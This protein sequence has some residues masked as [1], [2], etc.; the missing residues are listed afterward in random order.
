MLAY[1]A[2]VHRTCAGVGEVTAIA[3][4]AEAG[5]VA[6]NSRAVSAETQNALTIRAVALAPNASA[7]AAGAGGDSIDAVV[8]VAAGVGVDEVAGIAGVAV[9]GDVAVNAIARPVA[10]LP[11]DT[12]IGCRGRCITDTACA[13]AVDARAAGADAVDALSG[14]VVVSP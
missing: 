9:A 13:V 12:G 3:G 7:V 4:V 14:G 6:D 5:D 11:V 10:S 8:V 1:N 2:V